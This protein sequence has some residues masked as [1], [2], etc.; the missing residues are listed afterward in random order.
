MAEQKQQWVTIDE[1]VNLYL[2]RSEQSVH[3]YMKCW[4]LAF[5]GMEQLGLDFFYR[6]KSVKLPVA[7]NFTVALPD[8]Y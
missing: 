8:D 4:H 6:I 3:K 1:C 2:D 7:A 5:Q